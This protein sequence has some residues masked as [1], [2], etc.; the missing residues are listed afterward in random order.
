MDP[1]EFR[2]P[3]AGRIVTSPEGY[4]AFVPAPLPPRLTFTGE[5]A[6]ALSRADAA[7]GALSGLG[8]EL[9][10]P[11]ALAAPF[12]RQEALCSSRIE[13]AD[14]SF[15]EF[16]LDEISAAPAGARFDQLDEV[17][18]VL[19]TLTTAWSGSPRRPWT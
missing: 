15:T 14:V 13:G 19:A 8:G 4:A 18:N 5:L 6:V 9:P 10:N 12:L 16:L 2:A 11:T 17:R 3:K 7:L 1:G